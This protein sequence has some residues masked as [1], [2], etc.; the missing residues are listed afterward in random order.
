MK[1]IILVSN[2]L[3][4]TVD[5]RKGALHYHH[6]VGGLA[7]GLDSF[8]QERECMWIGW[9]G[10][11]SDRTKASEKKEITGT[12]SE[13][14][15]VP[16]FL[17]RTEIDK[18]YSGFSNRTIWPLF[19]YF[20]QHA[21]FQSDLWESYV[22]VNKL[23]CKEIVKH[24]QEGDLIWVHDYQ[25]M[26]LPSLLRARMPNASIG[27]FLHIPFPSVETFRLLP[28]RKELLLGLLGS[29]LIGFHTYDYLRH[30]L[31]STRRLLGY[32]STFCQISYQGRNIKSD[33]FPMGIDYKRFAQVDTM[34][35]VKKEERN[36][37]RKTGNMKLIIAIDRLDYT[38]GIL[39][40][41]EAF[42][43]FLDRY[44][45]QK[46][47][48]TMFLIEVPS[49]TSVESY[50][51]LKKQIDELIGRI[52][53]KHGTIGW[54]PVLNLYRT[55]PFAT[56]GALYHTCD[57][58]LVTP[59]RDG[60]N[61]V[62]KEY[63]AAKQNKPGVLILSEMAGAAR[64]MGE[65]LIVNPN[66]LGEIAEA[67]R[68]SLEMDQEEQTSRM[69]SMQTRLSRY[70]VKR[71]AQDFVA[72]LE[73]ALEIREKL[74]TYHLSNKNK[75]KLLQEA[76]QSQ[77][78]LLM[79]DY[80]GTLVNFKD[81][82]QRAYPDER[83]L[84]L[85]KKLNADPATTVAI[86]SGRDK[87]SLDRWFGKTDLTICAEHGVW[88]KEPEGEWNTIEPQSDQWKEEIRPIMQ[89]FTDRTPGTLLEEKDFSLA[90]HYR[91]ADPELASLRVRELN[92]A[93]IHLVSNLNLSVM[94]GNKV[95][96]VKN[97][98]INKGIVALKLLER[99]EWDL[100]I[101]AGDDITDEYLFSSLPSDAYSIKVGLEPNRASKARFSLESVEHIR[102][103]L[104]QISEVNR[105]SLQNA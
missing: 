41:L 93:L 1:R 47:K 57:V 14:R 31:N 39:Q 85:L 65:A 27:F 3:P 36:I 99:R 33:V 73:S 40:R 17:S 98:G 54:V 52:N 30:F 15:C 105:S 46:G 24:A 5:K 94:E 55:L 96:E 83:L 86:I 104:K 100:V 64:E 82:P 34:P 49:R 102:K 20:P 78:T 13:S 81:K 61:L 63:V 56:L 48:V 29:D 70:D 43:L 67:I 9:P 2:R 58:A 79:L 38:K 45:Q 75:E 32:E 7:T 53:G 95:L 28:W 92:D 77:S 12:L 103:L 69:N 16:V 50:R 37:R 72:K 4:I 90:F 11:A 59:L 26:L 60:M 21:V 74:K 66:N 62:A 80:D 76:A 88:I 18:F 87:N 71:W 25:L 44:P 42:D 23:F 8:H 84:K 22:H 97:A 51:Q 68:E 89:L 10:I 101:A 6:S 91:N 19:H 35:E